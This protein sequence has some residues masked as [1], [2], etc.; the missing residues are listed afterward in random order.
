MNEDILERLPERRHV[1]NEH[2]AALPNTP[3]LVT[4]DMTVGVHRFADEINEQH[5]LA[6]ESFTEHAI[7]C[8]KL[9]FEQ[10]RRVGYG[11]FG[12]WIETNCEFSVSTANNYMRMAKNPNALGKSGAIRRLYPSGF[13]NAPI[14]PSAEK[15]PEAGSPKAGPARAPAPANAE[16]MT[17][18][19][20]IEVLRGAER[21][22]SDFHDLVLLRKEQRRQVLDLRMRL[23]LAEI[24]LRNTEATIVSEAEKLREETP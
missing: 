18:G 15:A 14:R 16:R 1:H 17:V 22:R 8:G 19:R 4:A 7:R 11:K 2:E 3:V 20:A 6:R 10:K 24:S 12:K 9:L 5:R 21:Y 13:T 23:E